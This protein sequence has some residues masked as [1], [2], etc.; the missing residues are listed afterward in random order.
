MAEVGASSRARIC[1]SSLGGGAGRSSF[2]SDDGVRVAVADDLQVQV[3]G[4]PSAGEHG[5]QL[6]PGFLPGDQA[7]HRVGGDAL[8]GV[9]G[10]RI[11]ELGR[12]GH[13]VGGQPGGEVAAGVP[14]GEVAVSADVGDG[15]P[16]AVLHPITAA[17]S[18]A[19][20]VAAGDD[21]IADAGQVPV[22]QLDFAAGWGV[23]ESVGAGAVVEFGDQLA[24]G[25]EHDRVHP[26]GP[27]AGPG[28]EGVLGGGGQ[29]ADMNPTLVEV[30][31]QRG[32]VAVAESEGGGG[33][34]GVGEAVQLG[35]LEGAVG[36]F[37]VAEDAAG[38]DGAE[39]LVVPD[40]PNTATQ[41]GDVLDDSVEGEGV[42]HP[43]FVDDHQG[44]SADPAGPVGQLAVLQGPGELGER[45]GA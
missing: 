27:V 5:V 25:G 16:V 10:G 8:G 43:G 34:G 30:E 2:G 37:D 6:L 29:V 11:P 19:A 9:D 45:V 38:A 20:V 1:S 4:G 28:S 42:G 15:P 33:F 21:H 39:L 13:V 44:G 35:E 32:R 3:V 41:R 23:S 31:V 26:G 12:L 14:D 22:G 24:G 36:V 7:V 17:E 18:E 40:Q